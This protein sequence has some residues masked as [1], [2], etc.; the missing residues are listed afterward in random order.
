MATN[1]ATYH[2]P[3]G[4]QFARTNRQTIAQRVALLRQLL[5]GVQSIG[6]L[7]CGDCSRQAAAYRDIGV[8]RYV[9]LDISPGIVAAN[10]VQGIEC[11][12]GDALDPEMLHHFL[13][14][15][16]LFFGPPLSVRC[17]GHQLLAFEQVTPTYAAFSQ[18]LW[19]ELGYHGTAVYICPNSTT[20]GDLRRLYEHIRR[21]RADVGLR[22]IWSSWSTET[23]LGETTPLR[24]KYI[25]AWFSTELP[26]A[27]EFRSPEVVVV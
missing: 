12:L 2:T 25:E 18:L 27:W 15:D 4:A 8:D 9:G 13:R 5:P 6:E 20:P 17:D 14:F 7:C 23:G 21:V 3:G 11:L 22:L 19:Q 26:D 16:L 10:Q 24:L 1:D